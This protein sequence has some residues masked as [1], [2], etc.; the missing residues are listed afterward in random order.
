M[1]GLLLLVA[2]FVVAI[3]VIAIVALVRTSR[4]RNLFDE[5]QA[6]LES[7]I[8]FL[9]SAVANLH[10]ELK[11]MPNALSPQVQSAVVEKPI[12]PDPARV[13]APPEHL[14]PNAEPPSESILIPVPP[15]AAP[16]F[17]SDERHAPATPESVAAVPEPIEAVLGSSQDMHPAESPVPPQETVVPPAQPVAEPVLEPLFASTALGQGLLDK[18]MSE[19]ELAFVLGHEISVS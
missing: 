12:G 11:D 1:E 2:G 16:V 15:G 14:K 10:R 9:E 6:D 17:M 13:W 19:D 8:R 4:L 5:S 3:P 7:R 18:M